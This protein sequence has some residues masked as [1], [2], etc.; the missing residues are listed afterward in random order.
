MEHQKHKTWG[1]GNKVKVLEC[2]QTYV[3]E[4]AIK[5]KCA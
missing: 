4:L 5:L 3:L 1:S 2:V